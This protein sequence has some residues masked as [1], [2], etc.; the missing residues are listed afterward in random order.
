MTSLRNEPESRG[1]GSASQASVPPPID[2]RDVVCVFDHRT[3]PRRCDGCVA[4]TPHHTLHLRHSDCRTLCPDTNAVRSM[5]GPVVARRSRRWS[6]PATSHRERW[7]PKRPRRAVRH[8]LRQSRCASCRFCRDPWGLGRHDP[9]KTRLAHGRIGRL[10]VPVHTV[11]FFALLDEHTPDRKQHIA[12][13]PTLK[14][15]MHRTVTAEFAWQRVP[16][17]TGS[18]VI[19]DAVERFALIGARPTGLCGRIEFDEQRLNDRVPQIIRTSP[20]GG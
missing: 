6:L 3:S 17:A 8:R 10:P 1:I 4:C 12:F 2:G 14:R 9:P 11:K 19:D 7:H 15:A 16:L 5:L 18:Q 20:D 13:N